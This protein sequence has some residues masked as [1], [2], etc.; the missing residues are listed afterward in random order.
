MYIDI[1]FVF[2]RYIPFF[3]YPYLLFSWMFEHDC[4]GTGCFGCLWAQAVLGVMY[5]CALYFCMCT[6][7]AQLSMFH[8]ERLFRHTL[9]IITIII[10]VR[11][12]FTY[13]LVKSYQ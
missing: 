11:C 5:A 12:G 3:K 6:C 8:R 7:S 4:L 2:Y 1:I 13:F 10:E 9:I